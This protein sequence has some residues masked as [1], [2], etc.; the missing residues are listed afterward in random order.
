V[1][2]A[3]SSP[4]SGTRFVGETMFRIYAYNTKTGHYDSLD[5]YSGSSREEAINMWKLNNPRKTKTLQKSP[6]I[7]IV[8]LLD[9]GGI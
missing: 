5:T 1:G 6:N 2:R 9:G 8:A 7:K 3:G 4:A